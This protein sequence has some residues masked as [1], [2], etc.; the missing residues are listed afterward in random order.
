MTAVFDQVC[1][2]LSA[3]NNDEDAKRELAT[4]ILSLV[5]QGE[6]DPMLLA[7]AAFHQLAETRR[8]AIE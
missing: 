4:A 8:Q 6:R 5:D 3:L 7:D 1:R 2:C